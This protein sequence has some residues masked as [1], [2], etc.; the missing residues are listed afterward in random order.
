M[1]LWWLVS[2]AGEEFGLCGRSAAAEVAAEA[3][4]K[5]AAKAAELR[6]RI[7]CRGGSSAR[8]MG[9]CCACLP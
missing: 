5:A 1:R 4:A 8:V 9:R 2:A 7:S 3:A 6:Y